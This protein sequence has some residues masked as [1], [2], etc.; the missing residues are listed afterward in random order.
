MTRLNHL[1]IALMLAALAV[2][3][4]RSASPSPP[5]QAHAGSREASVP[6][7]VGET[8]TYDVTWA[9]YLV[10]G[11]AVSTV[12]EQRP[13]STTYYIVIAGR[14]VP[15]LPRLYHLYYK[16]ETLLDSVT[17]LPERGPPYSEEEDSRRLAVT[18]FD[19]VA[20]KASY[21]LQQGAGL[22]FDFDVPQQVQDGLSAIYVLRPMTFKAGG[23][24]TLPVV[25][26]GA[27]YTVQAE[28][29]ALEKVRV[30]MCEV[31]A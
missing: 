14:P 5:A 23:R 4:A 31:E 27:L 25:D 21:E 19:R 1:L 11:T 15:L 13:G 18:R 17:L 12:V 28:T 9:S 30:P 8:L 10:A 16:M 26:D 24:M 6:F 3:L 22:K 7:N 2:P 29:V 20:R